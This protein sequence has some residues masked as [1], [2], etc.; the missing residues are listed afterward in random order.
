M[1]K[2]SSFPFVRILCNAW[3]NCRYIVDLRSRATL[4]WRHNGHDNVSNHQPHDCFSTIYLDTD[5]RKDQSSASLAFVRGNHRRPMNSPHKWPVTRKMFP[6]DDVIMVKWC[7]LFAYD[8]LNNPWPLVFFSCQTTVYNI[9]APHFPKTKLM[10][11]IWFVECLAILYL[12]FRWYFIFM[13]D[14][15]M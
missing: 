5:E 6:F 9:H 11:C 8:I 7:F 13:F 4:Q 12:I 2:I 10:N 15:S 14:R 1:V 3:V